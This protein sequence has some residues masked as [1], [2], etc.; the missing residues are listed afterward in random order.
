MSHDLRRLLLGRTKNL[1]FDAL[2]VLYQ[3]TDTKSRTIHLSE[4]CADHQYPCN[5]QS[6]PLARTTS[7]ASSANQPLSNTSQPPHPEAMDLT[8]TCGRGK[9][10]DEDHAARLRKG[11]CLYCCGVGHMARH[12]PNTTRNSSVLLLLTER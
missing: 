5:P 9:I 7:A 2:V 8:T 4:G 10:S 11:H 1:T 6:H 3:N 12:C